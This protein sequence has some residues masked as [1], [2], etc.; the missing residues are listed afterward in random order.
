MELN[1][2]QATTDTNNTCTVGHTGTS[3]AAPLAAGIIALAL[4]AKYVRRKSCSRQ[5]LPLPLT[6]SN[7][8]DLSWR[9]V[10]HLVVATADPV[11]LMNNAGWKRNRAGIVFNNRCI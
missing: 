7:S 5:L 4:E 9:D 6:T 8:G 10:Q 3:A 11:P 2:P 1:L